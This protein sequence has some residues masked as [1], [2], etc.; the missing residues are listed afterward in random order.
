MYIIKIFKPII[1]RCFPHIVNL[2]C[3][4]VLNSITDLDYA[5]ED[6]EEYIS[7]DNYS[8]GVLPHLK[9]DPVATL[10]SLINAVCAVSCD[11]SLF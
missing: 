8:H 5:A 1:Y 11:L 10:R 4:A 7:E 3:K 9:K 2:G 6:V